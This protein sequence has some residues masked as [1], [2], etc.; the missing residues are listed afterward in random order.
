MILR[1]TCKQYLSLAKRVQPQKRSLAW[2]WTFIVHRTSRAVYKLKGDMNRFDV[3]PLFW[4]SKKHKDL[5]VATVIFY[6]TK[7][8][9]QFDCLTLCDVSG[10]CG[11]LIVD[12][13]FLMSCVEGSPHD[14]NLK[15]GI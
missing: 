6:L 11:S 10:C 4:H 3:D 7:S 8:L 12:K 2:P 5:N 14:R 1:D 13:R 9:I 15:L